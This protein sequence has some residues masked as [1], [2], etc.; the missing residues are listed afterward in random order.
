MVLVGLSL[1][2]RRVSTF[3]NQRVKYSVTGAFPCILSRKTVCTN[4]KYREVINADIN[5]A[6]NI[7]KKVNPT[8]NWIGVS[9]GV[10]PTVR[11]SFF[12]S[13]AADIQNITSNLDYISGFYLLKLHT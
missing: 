9:G 12:R 10:N 13:E 5:G 2:T 1:P 4:L 8:P 11:M 6:I 3:L 7:L